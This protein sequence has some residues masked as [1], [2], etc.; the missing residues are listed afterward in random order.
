[1]SESLVRFIF[2]STERPMPNPITPPTIIPMF[3]AML[4]TSSVSAEKQ[5]PYHMNYTTA[6][7]RLTA[8]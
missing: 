1:M 5:K 4:M 2:T 8:T 6:I 7:G 3:M